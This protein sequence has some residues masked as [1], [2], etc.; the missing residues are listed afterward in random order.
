MTEVN[1]REGQLQGREGADKEAEQRIVTEKRKI[2]E[3]NDKVGD[4]GMS[5]SLR[6]PLSE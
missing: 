3:I 5:R 2:E 4:G 6:L 1:Y